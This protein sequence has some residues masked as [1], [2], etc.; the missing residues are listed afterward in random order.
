MQSVSMD[1]GEKGTSPKAVVRVIFAAANDLLKDLKNA[2]I[3]L[4][5]Q[6][7]QKQSERKTFLFS[8]LQRQFLLAFL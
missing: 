8:T 1:A 2:I 5:K 6:A 4:G 3:L 7:S